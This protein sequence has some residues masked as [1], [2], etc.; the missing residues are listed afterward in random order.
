MRHKLFSP[1][2]INYNF[3]TLKS[4]LSV[5][6]H[7]IE[8]PTD[9]YNN[10]N[11]NNENQ[12]LIDVEQY[13]LMLY[14]QYLEQMKAAQYQNNANHGVHPFTQ[15]KEKF[16]KLFSH[17]KNVPQQDHKGIYVCLKAMRHCI[18]HIRPPS[19]INCW[20]ELQLYLTNY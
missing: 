18:F 19:N 15:L 16:K 4:I 8:Y 13:N 1:S 11:Q 14:N 2:S 20:L 10:E 3:L 5:I 6:G 9:L 17:H 7:P 12:Y